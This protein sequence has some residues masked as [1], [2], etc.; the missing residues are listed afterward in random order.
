MQENKLKVY[1][2][3]EELT[4][5]VPPKLI[6]LSTQD[7]LLKHRAIEYSLLMSEKTEN[8]TSIGILESPVIFYNE[9]GACSPIVKTFL[10]LGLQVYF[11]LITLYLPVK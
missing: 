4:C 11:D 10:L 3:G 2:S 6:Q 1:N 7:L 5:I 8:C 9:E